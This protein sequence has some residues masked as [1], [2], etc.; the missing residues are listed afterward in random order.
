MN[1]QTTQASLDYY[2]VEKAIRYLEEHFREQPNLDE[3]AASVHL[4]KYHFQRLF[5]R[6]AGVTPNQFLQF[7]TVSYAKERLAASQSVFEASLDAGLS[8]AGRLHDLFVTFEAMTPGEFKQEGEGLAITYGFHDTPFGRC[9]L[10]TTARGICALRFITSKELDGV[11]DEPDHVA[12]PAALSE[13]A[14]LEE[15]QQEWPRASFLEDPQ[16]TQAIVERIF[17]TRAKD[18]RPFHLL[19]KGTNFQVQVWRALLDIPPGAMVSYQGLAG[20]L[21]HLSATRAVAGAVAKNPIGYLI[22]CH[23]VINKDGRF[24]QYRWGSSR[25]RAILGWEAGRLSELE[26]MAG[27]ELQF[28]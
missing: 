9:L 1:E 13:S 26:Q 20:H 17:F 7:L 16:V 27:E 3:L 4:S 5:K 21:D 19:L 23:R 24:H 8:G 12:G 15:L 14:A 11:L 25:K 10:A 18:G 22:P 2:R 28:V 6:W